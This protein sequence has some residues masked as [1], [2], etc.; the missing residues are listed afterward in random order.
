MIKIKK[1]RSLKLGHNY[2]P[3]LKDSD[4]KVLKSQKATSN[5]Y[6]LRTCKTIIICLPTPIKGKKTNPTLVT[7]ILF[8]MIFEIL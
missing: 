8:L 6:D 4:F 5:I 7:L 2:L 1:I 3:H